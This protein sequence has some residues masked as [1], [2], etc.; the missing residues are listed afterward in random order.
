LPIP[1]YASGKDSQYTSL[2]VRKYKINDAGILEDGVVDAEIDLNSQKLSDGDV[3]DLLIDNNGEGLQRRYIKRFIISN[4]GW[5]VEFPP[6]LIFVKRTNETLDSLGKPV[7][8]SNFKPAA[9][10]SLLISYTPMEGIGE[11][12]WKGFGIGINASL[13]DF[14]RD[15]DFE[16]GIGL[17]VY[18]LNRS[19]G[20]GYGWDIH[21]STGST[22]FCPERSYYFLSLDFLKAF[23]TFSGFMS[24]T[25][26]APK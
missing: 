11:K 24:P 20:F 25:S 15:K 23:D 4:Y 12:L 1:N 18:W 5:N 22:L 26:S 9:G 3:L 10:G 19:V 2:A 17:I 8:P 16:L 14:E 13:V 6:S 21:A 7:N